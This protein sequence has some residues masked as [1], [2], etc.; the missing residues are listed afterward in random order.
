[1]DLTLATYRRI[2]I[3]IGSASL[4]DQKTGIRSQW[5]SSLIDDI[6]DIVSRGSD[7]LIVS[8]G[9][10]A[11]GRRI[12]AD[13]GA[14]MDEG[15]L[16]LRDSQ[17]AAAIGQ[18]ALCHAW[19]DALGQKGLTAAQILL[20]LGDTEERRKYLNARDTIETTLEWNAV[21]I[22]NENDSVATAEIRYGDNDRLAARVASLANADLLI[23]LSDIDGLYTA[24][25]HLHPNAKHIPVVEQVT[26]EI[27][28]MGGDAASVYSRG[29]MRTKI[30]AAQLAT[31]A[32][33]N[34][35]ITSANCLNPLAQLAQGKKATWFLASPA[36]VN[37]WKR[38]IAGG[39]DITGH[40]QIDA[41][42]LEALER[43][44]SL[45]P[46]GVTEVVGDF[47]RGD[48]VR[49]IGPHGHLVGTGLTQFDSTDAVLVVGLKS[50][51]IREKLGSS[52]RTEFIHRNDMAVQI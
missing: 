14:M 12:L 21:P 29:G 42:A 47:Q 33:V 30:E 9:A 38:W 36:P 41:G 43:G 28:A 17:A 11:L 44:K 23:L 32:G 1:M 51:E 22:I 7:V 15:D 40:Y 3:K 19:S 46:V 24:P 48:T 16:S 2:V 13:S 37:N 27:E 49:I 18:I 39:L 34:M 26:D 6:S 25:P 4:V 20:T 50:H 45:L 31:T 52:I 10:I 5:L 35:I 8:S